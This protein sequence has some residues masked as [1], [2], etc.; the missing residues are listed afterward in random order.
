MS[1]TRQQEIQTVDSSGYPVNKRI[2][3]AKAAR[4]IFKG[5]K[6]DNE[7]AALA[8]AELQG[9]YDGNQ[10]L[11]QSQLT[12]KGLAWICNVDWG[13]FRSSINL[14][15]AS[16]WN[17]LV[18]V[19]SFLKLEIKPG[20]RD[21]QNPYTDWGRQISLRFTKQLKKWDGFHF[22]WM[23]RILE[24]FK[25][26]NGT[27]F[28]KNEKDW[29]SE[30]IRSSNVMFPA[31]TKSAAHSLFTVMIR[32]EM[33][34]HDL[35]R[36]LWDEEAAKDAGWNVKYVRQMLVSYYKEKSDRS[37]TD[38]YNISDWESMQMAIINNDD[39]LDDQFDDIRVVHALSQEFSESETNEVT[40]QIFL[41]GDDNK[42]K[43]LF[44]K[45]NRFPSM[46][47]TISLFMFHIGDGLLK[48]V[49]GL[50]KE[51]FNPCHASNRLLGNILD[52][53]TISAG[54]L[55]QAQDARSAE[56]AGIIRKGPM[57]VV[58]PSVKLQQ[59]QVMPSMKAPAEARGLIHSLMNNNAGTY[60]NR[61]ESLHPRE[62]TAE[63]VRTEAGNEARFEGNQSEWYY[64]QWGLWLEETFKRLLSKDYSEGDPGYEQH[65]E[66]VDLLL[67]DG[68]PEHLIDP[69]VWEVSAV[70]AIGLGSVTNRLRITN[71]MMRDRGS[72]NEF[73]RYEIEREWYA[74]RVGEDNADRFVHRINLDEI[75]SIPYT[76]AEG[77]NNDMVQGQNR[78]V[79]VDDPHKIHADVHLRKAAETAKMS[80][81]GQMSDVSN[82]ALTMK[83]LI[84][85]TK[86]HVGRL[87]QDK[88][89]KKIV[90]QYLDSISKLE[91]VLKEMLRVMKA[92]DAQRQKQA[93]EQRKLLQEA[94][95]SKASRELEAK[96]YEIDRQF[97]LEKYKA[98]LL[99]QARESKT[100]TSQQVQ[101]T[102]LKADL[103]EQMI[104][105]R[106]DLEEK[107]ARAQA[108]EA[109]NAE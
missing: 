99:N 71:D 62:R 3:T 69:D 1:D 32:D 29:R 24:M 65:K 105:L 25:F 2:A 14:N 97:E 49:R 92:Q 30:F 95:A 15:A 102:K 10:P 53:V 83:L 85:H 11:S 59:Q 27:A 5:M 44:E 8:R 82:V 96:K 39:A 36:K 56:T 77:E 52:G 64:V 74:A 98:D 75:P 50:G 6:K 12:R 34:V 94:Q 68:V 101:F 100:A 86:V 80:A 43:F 87:S 22:L 70:K 21:T 84:E 31:K 90:E 107:L 55:A 106:A 60:K 93:E 16:V 40:H 67:E 61:E 88:T 19:Q 72:R 66:L 7:I 89:R 108:Q 104:R 51:L 54:I 73:E 23:S 58:T 33:S 79:A 20:H 4:N 63:E 81:S 47:G 78:T 37:T 18:S 57:T 91:A 41:E 45:E 35:V 38:K 103:D 46:T 28:W 9:L 76:M 26:G 48:S 13:E 109:Q 42:N 17:M